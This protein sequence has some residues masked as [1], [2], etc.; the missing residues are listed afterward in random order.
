[1]TICLLT[2]HKATRFIFSPTVLKTCPTPGLRMFKDF[3]SIAISWKQTRRKWCNNPVTFNV[4]F[5]K[6]FI[7]LQLEKE[8]NW[9]RVSD[10]FKTFNSRVSYALWAKIILIS[11]FDFCETGLIAN[12]FVEETERTKRE[13]ESWSPEEEKQLCSAWVWIGVFT[14]AFCF[15]ITINRC[16]KKIN[17]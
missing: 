14:Q 9:E 8:N 10:M 7:F 15:W 6:C 4:G 12:P 16:Y 3:S 11:V 1:M 13:K 5:C 2:R 17:K